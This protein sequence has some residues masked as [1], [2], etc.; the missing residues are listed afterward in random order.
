MFAAKNHP[1]SPDA[2]VSATPSSLRSRASMSGV[3]LAN[4]E[5]HQ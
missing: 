5:V 1:V 3:G 2:R 4:P